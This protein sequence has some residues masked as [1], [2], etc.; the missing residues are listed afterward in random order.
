MKD[1][2]G[3]AGHAK[4]NKERILKFVFEQAGTSRR[5]A[6]GW[7][8]HGGVEAEELTLPWLFVSYA[9]SEVS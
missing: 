5:L 1:S 9:G 2:N 7:D 3:T 8:S 6:I 4:R